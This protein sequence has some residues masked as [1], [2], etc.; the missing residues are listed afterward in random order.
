MPTPATQPLLSDSLNA[1]GLTSDTLLFALNYDF[2]PTKPK[3]M[4]KRFK[5]N[6]GAI[7]IDL[8]CVL[9]D[10]QCTIN[11]LVWFKQLR[12]KAESVRHQGDS[13]DGKDRGEQ[14]MYHAPLDQEQIRLYLHKIPAHITHIA[15]IA[16]S[17]FG[18][19]F[20]AVEDGEIHL[21]DDEGNRA[22][23]VNLKQLP[24]DCNAVW[25]ASLRREVSDWHLSLQNLPLTDNDLQKAAQQVAHE[26]ARAL[27]VPQG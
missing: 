1:L 18:Q 25:I 15:L 3:G 11:D 13:L 27:P 10:D 17:Y 24:R 2:I 16:S 7:D 14:A 4:M 26:L 21:S 8:A 20:M 23:E 6:Q 22:F 9:Y 5:E 19:P 12:D